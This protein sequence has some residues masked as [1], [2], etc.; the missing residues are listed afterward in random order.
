MIDESLM[1]L[2][3]AARSL[4]HK[5][6]VATLYRWMSRGVRGIRLRTILVGGRRYTS[7][8]ALNEFIEATSQVGRQQT[9]IAP[10]PFSA[11]KKV[12]LAN[13]KLTKLLAPKK[14]A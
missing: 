14:T 6:H 10:L 8:E 9:E 12:V 3:E 7:R 11:P 4:P 1:T 5:P 13:L 2:A